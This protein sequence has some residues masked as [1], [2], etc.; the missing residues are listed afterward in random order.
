VETLLAAARST[1][2]LRP[3]HMSNSVQAEWALVANIAETTPYGMDGL[4]RTGSKHFSPGTKVYCFPALWGDGY[5]S[6][7]VIGRHRGSKEFV[8]LV[9]P[10]KYLVN[11]RAK[12]VYNPEVLRRYSQDTGYH[13]WPS[14]EDVEKYVSTIEYNRRMICLDQTEA[15]VNPDWL[16]WPDTESDEKR[17]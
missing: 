14:R 6:A 11:P 9:I 13:P 15:N 12:V 4:P 8:T 5:S 16:I 7:K 10:T 2:A 3:K 17:T 1:R